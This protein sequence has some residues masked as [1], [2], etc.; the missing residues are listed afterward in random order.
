MNSINNKI[1]LF[2]TLMLLGLI[3]AMQGKS[4]F[5]ISRQQTTVSYRIEKYKNQLVDEQ[6]K[7]K[8][9]KNLIIEN[10][11]IN[12]ISLKELSNS[13]SNDTIKNL[14]DELKKIKFNS[15][16][17]DVSGKGIKVILNDAPARETENPNLLIIHDS[18]VYGMVNELK[19]A[20]AQAI[21]IN[22][23]R[24]ISNSEQVCAGPTIRINKNRYPVPYEILAIGDPET[25]Y[26]SLDEST[27]V[28]LMRDF[29]IGVE[30]KKSDNIV[31]PQYHNK[32]ENLITGL[33]VIK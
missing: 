18:D 27:P 12:D 31:I 17:T 1:I 15:G 22:G 13:K 30:I 28:I 16:L 9:L 8:E 26:K 14:G 10:Q 3:M 4:I 32:L 23:E 2:L 5:E 20:G 29:D 6:E 33:E 11:N 24:I 25:L 21:S 7:S 19:K